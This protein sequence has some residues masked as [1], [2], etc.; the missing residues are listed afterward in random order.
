MS[1]RM[2]S[3]LLVRARRWRDSSGRL[4]RTDPRYDVRRFTWVKAR[5]L[6]LGPLANA[7]PCTV[8]GAG[9]SGLT[10]TRFLREQGARR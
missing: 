1:V 3:A 7:R 9:P 8:W 10:L 6:A 5:Y 2:T 4:T